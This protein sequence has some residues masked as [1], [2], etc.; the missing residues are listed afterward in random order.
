MFLFEE[1]ISP[2]SDTEFAGSD[3]RS[4]VSPTS[5]YYALKDL[6]NQLRAAERNALVD[7]EG[8][9][10]LSRDWIPL[11]EQCSEAIKTESKDIEY[12]AWL[13]EGLCRVHGFKGI[14]FGFS[15][16]KHLLEHHFESLYPTL[17][18]GDEISDKVS[19][20]VGL[21]GSA[22]EGT[23]II[24][25]KSIYMTDSVSMDPFSFWEYQ[26]G[27]DISRLSD[28]KRE[29]KITQGAVD[30]EQLEKS[31]AETS[32]EFFVS[33]KNDIE[34]AIEKFAALSEVMDKVTGEPQPT[35]NIKQAL[36]VSLAAVNHVAA[37][38]LE[39]AQIALDKANAEPEEEV[40][41]DEIEAD[42]TQPKKRVS[43]EIDSRENAIKKLQEIAT[44]FRKTEP[45]S[46]MSYTIEQVIRW[47]ELSLPE[48]LNELITDSDARTGYFKLSGIKISETET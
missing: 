48:L 46:P 27:Y 6:R 43:D 17:D 9:A 13:I 31:A 5:T 14:A 44:F 19:A 26:Q 21:N 35:S 33:L 11:L 4:D 29:K 15:V 34:D 36:E 45:H 32:T 20:L 25:I 39:A 12:L 8:I 42:S 30:F 2:I 16:A 24:P 47:S 28:E 23:L 1:Y 40:V 18:D 37:D 7:E 10:S 41:E 38:K 3:P 22:G